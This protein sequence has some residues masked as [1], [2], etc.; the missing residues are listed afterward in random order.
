[1]ISLWLASKYMYKEKIKSMIVN[2]EVLK[3]SQ[4]GKDGLERGEVHGRGGGA[5]LKNTDSIL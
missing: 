3:L 2:A 5:N 1:M 4:E